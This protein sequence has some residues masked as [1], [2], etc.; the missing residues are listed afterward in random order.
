MTET[1]EK[2]TTKTVVEKFT[3]KSLLQSKKYLDRRD[4]LNVLIKDDE[5][6]TLNEIDKRIEKFMKGSVK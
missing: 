3:K 1:K 5:E 6:I 2:K 4:I